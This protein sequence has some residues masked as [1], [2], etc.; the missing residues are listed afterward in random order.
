M[1]TSGTVSFNLTAAQIIEKAF[2]VLGKAAEG[3]ALTPRMLSDG[4]SSFNLLLKTIGAREGLWQK[5]ER[6][7]ALIASTPSYGLTPKPGRV[8]SVRIRNGDID[9]PLV[10]MTREEY[11]NMAAKVVPA[12][13]PSSFYYD[14]QRSTGT[15]YLW[16]APSP[17]VA[18]A[19]TL[20]L[21]YL[22]RIEDMVSTND[23]LDMP[24]EWLETVVWNL[25]TALETEY[26]VNDQRLAEKIDKRAAGLLQILDNWDKEA[27]DTVFMQVPVIA[28]AFELIQHSPVTAEDYARAKRSL[29]MLI[30][31][32]T[33]Q[34]HLW[35]MT[36]GTVA[37]VAGQAAYPITPKPQRVLSVR[38][39]TFQ[40]IDVP[41]N[42]MARSTYD[43]QP[44]KTTSPSTPVSFY[45]DPQVSTGT[46]Y[47]WPA[48][49]AVV[50]PT[51]TIHFTY[52]RAMASFD[53]V[54]LD[55]PVEWTETVAWNLAARLKT[56]YPMEDKAASQNIDARSEMLFA[57]LKGWDNE[58]AS[59]FFQPDNMWDGCGYRA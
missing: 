55:M 38:R 7:L 36:E 22:R 17:A 27:G 11:F 37:L 2:H 24:Q 52:L 21:T 16:P 46:L 33:A 15:L 44:N 59:L 8:L 43:D 57:K 29:D 4:L 30:G 28:E 6:S 14:P 51:I 40:G 49:A 54:T 9:T 58:P 5:T 3:E 47:L 35:T 50:V 42:E 45:Y 1:S 56:K 20:E 41:L 10:E 23:D 12:G 53:G 25:A 34:P 39:R 19:Q 13:T 18:A 32:W 26:P 31:S 48:P